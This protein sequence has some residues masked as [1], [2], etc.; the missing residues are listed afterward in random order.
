MLLLVGTRLLDGGPPMFRALSSCLQALVL[1]RPRLPLPLQFPLLLL[2]PRHCRHLPPLFLSPALL[3]FLSVPSSRCLLLLAF[4]SFEFV[5]EWH[6]QSS[7]RGR[8]GRVFSRDWFRS[9]KHNDNLRCLHV[10]V[11][12]ACAFSR[13]KT[14][15]F[16][17]N[18]FIVCTCVRVR[19]WRVFCTC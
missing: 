5:S 18:E 15:F 3:E 14:F 7:G 1:H 10:Y 16:G 9:A 13:V 17:V 4:T 11:A 2:L 6:G 12:C 19:V 8:M